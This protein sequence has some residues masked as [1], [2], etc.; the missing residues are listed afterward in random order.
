MA[1]RRILFQVQRR[2][3]KQVLGFTQAQPPEAPSF[4]KRKKDEVIDEKNAFSHTEPEDLIKYGMIPEFIGRLPV[5]AAL[6]PLSKEDLVKI[7]TEPK[8]AITKQYEKLLEMENVKLSFDASSLEALA[9][10]A[11]L[12]GTGARGL[13]A[14]IEELMLEIMFSVPSRDDVAEC[15]ITADTVNGGEPVIVKKVKAGKPSSSDT[16]NHKESA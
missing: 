2:V 15:V 5:V 12:K 14:L 9:E 7:L 16:G 6:N 4:K 8:N 11:S 13:R 1:F 3:G 10:K